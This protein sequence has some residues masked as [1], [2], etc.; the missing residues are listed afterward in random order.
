MSRCQAASN[1]EVGL[2]QE[3]VARPTR[4]KRD[5]LVH[6]HEGLLRKIVTSLNP[7]P[8]QYDDYLQVGFIGLINAIDRYDPRFG[9]KFST[10]ATPTIAGEIRRYK[11]DCISV[12]K[13]RRGSEAIPAYFRAIDY[14][15][16]EYGRHPANDT[17]LTAFLGCSIEALSTVAE[18]VNLSQGMISL[19]TPASDLDLIRT[20]LHEFIADETPDPYQGTEG[21]ALRIA[22][23]LLPNDRLRR[24]IK[25]RF[26]QGL[27][28]TEVGELLGISQMH[29]SRL[30][31]EAILWLRT[32]FGV[33]ELAVPELD[34]DKPSPVITPSHQYIKEFFI[35]VEEKER[36]LGMK[37]RRAA[38][39]PGRRGRRMQPAQVGGSPPV[40]GSQPQIS[41][42]HGTPDL[43]RTALIAFY[44]T[45]QRKS[46]DMKSDRI[47]QEH[48][49]HSSDLDTHLARLASEN[50]LVGVGV[51]SGYYKRGGRYLMVCS[52]PV[53]ETRPDIEILPTIFPGLRIEFGRPYNLITVV[54]NLKR[55]EQVTRQP[56]AVTSSPSNRLAPRSPAPSAPQPHGTRPD[57]GRVHSLPPS[58]IAA[59]L[60]IWP[61]IRDDKPVTFNISEAAR[62][63][64]LQPADVLCPMPKLK[65]AGFLINPSKGVYLRGSITRFRCA[66]GKVKATEVSVLPKRYPRLRLVVGQ[67]YDIAE[68]VAELSGQL[69]APAAPAMPAVVSDPKAVDN[70]NG[71][72]PTLIGETAVVSTESVIMPELALPSVPRTN[73]NDTLI[74]GEISVRQNHLKKLGKFRAQLQEML[75]QVEVGEAETKQDIDTLYAAR[76]VLTK[77]LPGL[78]A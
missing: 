62:E 61:R 57:R 14:F 58:L 13:D 34:D 65:E 54:V 20:P 76:K 23:D 12:M 43:F 45:A 55:G 51:G 21:L 67:V 71:H 3:Y 48:K 25:W 6:K 39:A 11:R 29:V 38:V 5:A 37:A 18:F 56:T 16:I 10:F 77:G 9:T 24:L 74:D 36:Q 78:Q 7:P 73:G 47:M 8:N 66:H 44:L 15:S 46:V 64:G 63:V 69:V 72:A 53:A 40:A 70:D 52:R 28:Q 2:W 31:R 19:D 42:V 30:Q 60:V 22:I 75:R 59:L 49:P 50:M 26:Y 68:L 35:A 17:E 1:E 27:S 32:Y 33:D 4:E 41:V